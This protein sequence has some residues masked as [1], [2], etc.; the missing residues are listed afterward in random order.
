MTREYVDEKIRSIINQAEEQEQIDNQN[1]YENITING[2]YYEFQ[3]MDFFEGKLTIHLPTAFFDMPAEMAKLKY[4]SS[5]RPQIIKTEDTGSINMTFNL[6]P[7]NI[8]DDHIPEVKDGIKTILKKL[9]PSYLFYEEGIERIEGKPIGFFEFKSPTLDEPLFN[10]MF[11]VEIEHHV[12]MGTFNCPY[13]EYR[14]WRQI[15]RQMMN[16][17]R[18]QVKPLPDAL[19]NSEVG[20]QAQ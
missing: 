14:E 4:P 20:G 16:S 1:I 19:N 11:V 6:I 15:A 18:V 8:G 5:D 12:M 13:Q 2:R 10:L 3:E 7:N 9:N 17:V